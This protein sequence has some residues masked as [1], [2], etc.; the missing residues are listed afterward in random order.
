MRFR[1]PSTRVIDRPD[2]FAIPG[3]IDAHGHME[4]LGASRE[5]VDLR[6]VASLEEVA[7]RVKA[8]GRR[9]A[10]RLVDHGPELG[11]EPLAGRRVPDRGRARR[12]GPEPAGLATA[13]RR[14]RRLGQLRGH[15]TREG[16][17][18]NPSAPRTARSSATR[19]DGRPASSS[20]AP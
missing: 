12:R 3:L 2:A 5:E 19:T 18:T 15:A 1:G 7:R 16:H 6:G 8:A 13:G 14:P 10:R 17:R 11:P 4:A 9:D 20:T